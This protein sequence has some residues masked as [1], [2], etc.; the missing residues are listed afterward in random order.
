MQHFKRKQDMGYTEQQQFYQN[1]RPGAQQYMKPPEQRAQ[2]QL[3]YVPTFFQDPK[4]VAKAH[5]IIKSTPQGQPL[6]DWIASQQAQITEAYNWFALQNKGKP[7]TEWKHLTTDDPALGYLATLQGPPQKQEVFSANDAVQQGFAA[8]E[9][10]DP[11]ERKAMLADPTFDITKYP[12]P[13]RDQ[14]LNDPNF[15][16]SRVPKWQRKYWEIMSNP[17]AI[18]PFGIDTGLKINVM[19]SPMAIAGMRAGGMFGLPGKVIGAY[20]GYMLGV[21][22]GQQ[23]DPTAGVFEQPTTVAGMMAVLNKLS[24]GSEMG[25]GYASQVIAA[26]D[27][28]EAGQLITDPALRRSAWE[29]GRVTYEA[30]DWFG[31]ANWI[32][33]IEWLLSKNKDD[34]VF[35]GENEDWIIG[36]AKPVDRFNLQASEKELGNKILDNT[37]VILIRARQQIHEAIVQGASEEEI[38]DTIRDI[39]A[40]E[41]QYAGAQVADFA[42]QMIIDPLEQ[43]PA[44]TNKVSAKLASLLG[45]ETAARSFMET[46]A[47]LKAA[48][49]YKTLVQSGDVPAGFSYESMGSVSRWIAG[50][51]EQ[52]QIRAGTFTNKGLLD[53]PTKQ[54]GLWNKIREDWTALTPEARAREGASMFYNNVGALLSTFDDPAEVGR[55]IH[56]LSGSDM[57]LW[58][59]MGGKIANS[60]EWYTIL[61]A[62]KAFDTGKLD[63]LTAAWELA[64]PK[65]EALLKIADVLGEEPGRFIDDLAKRGTAD[66][67]FQRVVGRLQESKSPQAKEIL[68][69]IQRGEFTPDSL[70]DIVDAFSGDGPLY[71]HPDQYKAATLDALGAHFDEWTATKLGLAN[72]PAA[73]SAFFRTTHLLKSAQSVLL[74]GFSPGYALQNGLSGMVHRAATGIYGY[75]TPNQTDAWLKRF[76]VEPA[77]LKEGV[78]I[79]GI[80]ES[81]PTKSKVQTTAI[82]KA[83]RGPEKGPLSWAQRQV[84]KLAKGMPMNKLSS[85]FESVEGKNGFMIAMRDMWSKTWRRGAG[86]QEMTPELK[87]HVERAGINPNTI[88]SLIE[89]GMNKAEI[90][91]HILGRQSG[92]LARSLVHDAAQKTGITSSQAGAML[93]KIGVLDDL[94]HTLAN[95]NTPDKV[96]NAFRQAVLK[97]QDYN[98][99]QTARDLLAMAED[100]KNKVTAE[101]APAALDVIQKVNSNY[102]D[103]WLDHYAR[104]GEMFEDLRE[105]PDLPTRNKAIEL[106]YQISDKEFRRI[107][108]RT[109]ANYQ[110]IFETWGRSNNQSARQ[111]LASLAQQDAA[112]KRAYDFMRQTRREYFDTYS[113]SKPGDLAAQAAWFDGQSKIDAEFALAFDQKAAAERAMGDAMGKLYDEMYGPAAGEAARKWWEDYTKFSADIVKRERK[114]RQSLA[115][116]DKD[117]RAAAKAEYYGKD[118]VAQIAELEKINQE[119]IQRL[120]KVIKRGGGQ[121]GGTP[122]TPD[123]PQGPTP[124]DDVNRLL[125]EAE[126]RKTAEI[127][128]KTQRESD[129]WTIASTYNHR[130]LPFDRS[131][132]QDHYAMRAILRNADYGG[133]PDLQN[134]WDERLTADT[135]HNVLE[136]YTATKAAE[137]AAKVQA[138]L[139]KVEKKAKKVI[140][141]QDISLLK[142]IQGHGGIKIDLALDLTGEKRP[143][144][145]PGL[146]TK[147][148]LALDD[149]ITRLAVEDKFPIDMNRPDDPGGVRQFTELLD[150][151]RRGERIYPIGR[152]YDAEILKAEQAYYTALA[153]EL[154]PAPFDPVQWQ[155]ELDRAVQ[156]GD[157]TAL[158]DRIGKL[159]EE[160]GN[161]WKVGSGKWEDEINEARAEITRQEQART[162]LPNKVKVEPLENGGAVI[163]FPDGGRNNLTAEQVAGYGGLEGVRNEVLRTQR[164]IIDSNITQQN[165]RIRERGGETWNDYMSRI[166]DETAARVERDATDTAIAEGMVRSEDTLADMQARGDAAMTR[167]LFREQIQEAFSLSD[168][169]ANAYMELSET[170]AGWYARQTGE[171]AD[172]FYSRYYEDVKAEAEGGG[173]LYQRG[174]DSAYETMQNYKNY[175]EWRKSL[176]LPEMEPIPET[177]TYPAIQTDDGG[178][179]VDTSDGPTT[180]ILFIERKGIPPQRIKDGGWIVDG[181]YRPSAQSDTARYAE[182]KKAEARVKFTLSKEGKPLYQ[183]QPVNRRMSAPEIEG[184]ARALVRQGADELRRAVQNEPSKADRI[185]ILNAAHKLNP[186]LAKQ[187]AKDNIGILFQDGRFMDETT[188]LSPKGA[189][190]FDADGIKATITAFGAKD[191]STLVHENA[192]VFRRMLADVA[193]RTDN[194]RVKA[195]LATLE[196]WAGVK[197]GVWNRAA[198]EKF[199]RGFEKYIADGEAPTPKLRQAFESFKQ[200]MLQVYRTITGSAIDV[201]ITPQ[202]KAIFD[203]LVG[204]EPRFG[205]DVLQEGLRDYIRNAPPSIG[206]AESNLHVQERY[207][208]SLE[209]QGKGDSPQAKNVRRQVE[210]IKTKVKAK[211]TN[212]AD[213]YANEVFNYGGEQKTRLEITKDL[214]ANGAT[215][216]QIDMYLFGLD[217]QKSKALFQSADKPFGTMD[218]ASGFKADSEWMDQGWTQNIKPLLDNM[219]EVAIDRLSNERPLDG[220][221]KDMTPEGQ[222]MLQQYIRQVQNDMGAVKLSTMKWGE[223]QRDFAMLNYNRRYGFDKY[224]EVIA[225]YQ[226]FYT[227]SLMTWGMRALDKPSW[228]AKYARIRNMQ[229]QHERDIPERLRNKFKIDAPWLPDWMGDALYI[230]PLSNL[231]TPANFLRPFETMM[232][233]KSQQQIEAERILQE[234]AADG[235]VNQDEILKAAQ[236]QEG[237][238]WERAQAEASIRREAQIS[239][240]FDFMAT[241]F[242]PAWYLSTPLN[243]LGIEVPF[244]SKGDPNKVTSTPLLNTSRAM[245]AVTKGT[246]AEPIGQ[247]IGLAGRPEQWLREKRGLPEFG[248]FGDYYVDRQIA[249]MVADGLITSQQAQMA[250]IERKGDIFEQARERVKMEL[251]LRTPLAG[252]VYAATHE[253]VGAAAQ[254]FLPSLFGSGLLPAGELEYRGLKGEW[255][256]AWKKYDAGD[257]TAVTTFFEEHP[258]YEAYLAKGKEPEERLRSFMIGNIWDAYM[259]LGDTNKKAAVEQMGEDFD[260]AFLDKET[261]SYDSIDVATLTRWA[262]ML[263]TMVPT[264]EQTLPQIQQPA[265]ALNLYDPQVTTITDHFFTERKE[266]YNDYYFLERGYY[267]LPKSERTAYL[268]KF[269]RLREYW[270]WKKGYYDKYPEL[271]PIFKGQVFKQVDTS[272]WPPALEEY[273]AMYAMTGKKLPKGAYKSLEQ[274]WIRE[275]MPMGDMQSWLDSQV[276]PAMLYQPGQ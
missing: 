1:L 217:R 35:A 187:V 25:I 247:L 231:F 131:I 52:G 97:A 30:A 155:A 41:G 17:V 210:Q 90:E 83:V 2:E 225:P 224:L 222:K 14:I 195:D 99:M 114:F 45:N 232:R 233:D 146:F 31:S 113:G 206:I 215:R 175:D 252:T 21:L 192:H 248:E 185:A 74:L 106:N 51:N 193:S 186:D 28:Q 63:G 275:G 12:V 73:K 116:K 59:D 265:P 214:E 72:D 22:G 143:R 43:L 16:W 150:S 88:Y 123:Q 115:G 202:V 101:G 94:D 19:A 229:N 208:A 126:Q 24:E 245:E 61:P 124:F 226:F 93:E 95:A 173:E 39:L 127:Q 174:Y 119:G 237:S 13:I 238:L 3:G 55:F 221:M 158:Y 262:Q 171:S 7:D 180:H 147:K 160:M 10:I 236:T 201:E 65:R 184:Y 230:D 34:V 244:L 4:E 263:Q 103:T 197:D 256:A 75:M 167:Q 255:N 179:Y 161:R 58:R 8:W 264:T 11:T 98:D 176:V 235:Q 162:E 110:A 199:A 141:D 227:R 270:D 80:V 220:A 46:N 92:I 144:G 57:K 241:M 6:P 266:K 243:L 38:R 223:S 149:L 152:S 211:R 200:W 69:S 189:V 125:A 96:R 130:S 261:R 79:G 122:T 240:P 234:W 157:L 178:L 32:P 76:G 165:V 26:K 137:E 198:E 77:R 67:D 42:G 23:Y 15:D 5:Q 203:R 87:S 188:G 170:I 207:L 133:F 182:Q 254:A 47:P 108:A 121:T 242:G 62:L 111:I 44:V 239:S 85:A 271:Q 53:A 107:N 259:A 148:G 84:S 60:P 104:F 191:F 54:T 91:R 117:A 212:I 134:L 129:V 82:D 105:I 250:M 156:D 216:Q 40:R 49:R 273:V 112:M 181:D 37:G 27:W 50:L 190:A 71:W 267:S 86:F 135:V 258:E 168:E 276:V 172:V 218:N 78:G 48:R 163:T 204:E 64:A 183:L 68:D 228:F 120:E 159:P 274:V 109:A 36:A 246:W 213:E 89:A 272:Q 151:A 81:A 219:Q 145:M 33:A 177:G 18:K 100:V 20:G 153:E 164:T 269:P 205:P 128:A 118:K 209:K 257:K 136:K 253:G 249:N 251:A 29:A 132:V 56:S 140:D 138:V 166:A 260:R 142:A 268:A 139:P 9:D 169:Q 194:K 70:K 102:F 154:Q 66:Q 196:E